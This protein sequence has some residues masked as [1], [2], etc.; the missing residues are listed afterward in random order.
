M[1]SSIALSV[2]ITVLAG[3]VAGPGPMLSE[4]RLAMQ[5]AVEPIVSKGSAPART[6]TASDEATIFSSRPQL[7]ESREGQ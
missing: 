3:A 1:L 6:D 5:A 7:P 2:L 4:R